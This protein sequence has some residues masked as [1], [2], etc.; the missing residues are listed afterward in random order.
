MS[1]TMPTESRTSNP[2]RRHTLAWGLAGAACVFFGVMAM[3]FNQSLRNDTH[4]WWSQVQA[5]LTNE[6][7]TY[8]PASVHT[9]YPTYRKVLL[10]M[11]SHTALGGLAMTLG[12]LQ[13]VPALRRRYPKAH[14]AASG[15]V[16]LG[17]VVSMMGAMTYLSRTPFTDIYASPSFGLALW[18]LALACLSYVVL[19]VLAI[20]RRDF[21]SHMGF[22]ALMM[23]TLLTAPVLRF[24]WALFGMALP[25]N[26]H[27]I[28]QGVVTSLAVITNLI[29]AVWMHHI[30]AADLPMRRRIAVPSVGLLRVLAYSAMGVIAHEAL[31]APWGLD[32]LAGWRVPQE[33]LPASA[34]LWGLS[35]IVLAW[36]VPREIVAVL[37]ERGVSTV[38]KALTASCAL[39]AIVIAS[40]HSQHHVDAIGLTF[41]WASYGVISLGLLAAAH[42]S[43]R[44]DEPW[45][46]MLLFLS[47]SAAVW[48]LLWLVGWW[49]AQPF[50][51]AMWFAAT[52]G[53][54][55]L[56]S[57]AFL[58]AFALRLPFF[59][60]PAHTS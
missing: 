12:V 54:A 33:Q 17:V 10:A 45:S 2:A 51:V 6:I 8:G 56:S 11:S 23:A 25:Y 39:G 28:N 14:R 49:C 5:G 18:A 40:G 37:A 27:G 1:V 21:R 50:V 31:L 15:V 57:S 16:L 58:T 34:A 30:G 35:A 19:A 3:Q 60:T 55:G 22:M 42:Y 48:P 59:H 24:E 53:A 4:G 36:R 13:F 41:Y 29:M 32:L 7:Y 26:M 47:L 43:T 46:L 38:S 52:V 44:K 20:R 9:M